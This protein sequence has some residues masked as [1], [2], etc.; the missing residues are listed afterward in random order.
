L[1]QTHDEKIDDPR[2]ERCLRTR[3]DRTSTY[4]DAEALRVFAKAEGR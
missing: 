4:S 3:E 1:A 2:M